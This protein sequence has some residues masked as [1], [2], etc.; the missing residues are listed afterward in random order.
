MIRYFTIHNLIHILND[1]VKTM[2]EAYLRPKFQQYLVD[3]IARLITR[4]HTIKPNHVTALSLVIGLFIPIALI[5]NNHLLAIIALLISGYLDT[6]DGTLA[7]IMERSSSIGA[8]LDIVFDRV[9]EFAIIYGLYLQSPAHRSHIAL[10][11]LGSSYVCVTSFLVVGI[12]HQNDSKKSFFYSPGLMERPEAFL[13][14]LLMIIIPSSFNILG[15]IYAV[16]VT[17][18]AFRRVWEFIHQAS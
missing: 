5:T 10:L 4:T 11:M 2:L 13:F 9:V 6:L 14:F 12:F 7:R 16:L 17:Y 18:T 3:P 8:L 1:G 15:S